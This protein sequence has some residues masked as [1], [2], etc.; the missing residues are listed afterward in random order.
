MLELEKISGY[1]NLVELSL[2]GNTVISEFDFSS[3]ANC[4]HNLN[5]GC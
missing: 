4:E 2:V 3:H 1:E 5:L